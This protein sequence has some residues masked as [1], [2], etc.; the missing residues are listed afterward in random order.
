[1]KKL[2]RI[3]PA[4]ISVLI[5]ML[6]GC[7]SVPKNS[8]VVSEVMLPLS[9]PDIDFSIPEKFSLTST[10]SNSNA[11]V[12]GN[13]SII[14]NEDSLSEKV[15]SLNA[16]VTYSKELY[17]SVADKYTEKNQEEISLNGLDGIITE[18]DYE[19][20]GK[21]DTLSMSCV[22]GFFNDPVNKPSEIYIV[23]CKSDSESYSDFRNSFLNTIKSVKLNQ[24]E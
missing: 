3:F 9:E 4:L 20:N 19:I 8:S 13:A 22:V 14:V 23:T 24:G 16:Y 11:Y 5:F 1:M 10:A 2:Y 21:E 6:C 17:Q 18:F 7:E 15:S 12:C